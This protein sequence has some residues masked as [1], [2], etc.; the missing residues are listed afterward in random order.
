MCLLGWRRPV[1]L[2]MLVVLEKV[3]AHVVQQK[4]KMKKCSRG[5]HKNVMPHI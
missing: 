2:K 4:L 5:I 1:R 3:H